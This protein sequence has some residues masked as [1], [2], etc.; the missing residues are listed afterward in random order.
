MLV[1]RLLS[2]ALKYEWLLEAW[3]LFS[4]HYHFVV[5]SGE[6]PEPLNQLIRHLHSVTARA[7]NA[8]DRTAGRKVRFEFWDTHLTFERSYRARLNY[9]HQNPVRH[10]LVGAAVAYPWCSAAWFEQQAD[11]SFFQTVS[12][13]PTDGVHVPDGW[14]VKLSS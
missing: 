10:G 11:R 13:F 2:L 3:A 14:D 9:V 1:D 5:V 7:V 6:K 8:L 4:N 12:S